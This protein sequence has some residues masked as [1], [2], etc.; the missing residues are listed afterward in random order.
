MQQKAQFIATVLHDP[1]ILILDEPL[2]GPRPVGRRTSC[3]TCCSTCG[4]RA[5]RSCSPAT[6]WRRW[7]GSATRSPSSTAG[8][9]CST[10]AVSEVKSRHGKNTV[11]LAYEGDGAFLGGLPGVARS[12][13]SAAT[14]RCGWREGAD[15]QA[16]LREASARLRVSRFEVVEPSLHD[17]FVQE[18]TAS[19]RATRR[20]GVISACCIVARREYLERVRSKAFVVEHPPGAAA[21]GGFMLVPSLLMEKQRGKP[22]RVAVLDETGDPARPK[23]EARAAAGR[24]PGASRFDAA[25]ARRRGRRRPGGAALRE[26]GR[27]GRAGRVRDPAPGGACERST[28]R[29]LRQEREQHHGHRHCSSRRW[30][31][32]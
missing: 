8:A 25:S 9:R 13:T 19:A 18:V 10:A 31:K 2:S 24:S 22:L 27:Q 11:V 23:V 28:R 15:P 29:V 30:R 1:E 12:A 32:P 20:P 17:I 16:I 14:W 26:R 7:S 5:G 21:H 3:A 6:R 4:A